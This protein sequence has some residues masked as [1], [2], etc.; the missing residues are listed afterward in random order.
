MWRR[1]GNVAKQ[2]DNS[3]SDGH[4]KRLS[5]D[6]AEAESLMNEFGIAAPLSG[7]GTIEV[8]FKNNNKGIFHSLFFNIELIYTAWIFSFS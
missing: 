8:C 7:L 3:V 2:G 1:A 4:P 5:F 6:I